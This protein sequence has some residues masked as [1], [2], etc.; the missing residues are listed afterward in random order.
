M[1]EIPW[2]EYMIFKDV[3]L[4]GSALSWI[5]TAEFL[6]SLL[7]TRYQ[8]PWI[9]T[10]YQDLLVV[11]LNPVK[12]GFLWIFIETHFQLGIQTVVSS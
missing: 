2:F 3:I 10:K 5:C 6:K 8:I 11:S 4:K 7:V 9:T 1:F 12:S